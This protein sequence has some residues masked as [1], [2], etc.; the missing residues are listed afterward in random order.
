MTRLRWVAVALSLAAMHSV[1][2]ATLFE[3]TT[4]SAR[5]AQQQDLLP[6]SVDFSIT[7]PGRYT[8]TLTD[9]RSPVAL[10]S[11][12]AV[13]TR[14]LDVVAKA[15]VAYEGAA[16]D[17]PVSVAV[18]FTAQAGSYRLH[19]IGEPSSSEP[20]SFGIGVAPAGG[21]TSLID[22]VDVIANPS[23]PAAGQTV[24]RQ[25]L[26]LTAAGNH[27]LILTDLSF[28]PTTTSLQAIVLQQLPTGVVPIPV[29]A[30]AFTAP[31]PG[32]YE[33]LVLATAADGDLAGLYSI[34]LRRSADSFVVYRSVQPAGRMPAPRTLT[35]TAG[36][37]YTLDADDLR[38]PAALSSLSAAVAQDGA[39]VVRQTD[40]DP[41]SAALSAGP[42]QLF[43]MATPS[44]IDNLG[45]YRISLAQGSQSIHSELHT[46]DAVDDPASAQIY[47]FDP[48]AAANAGT[49]ALNLEDL[50][51]PAPLPALKAAVVQN[52][53]VVH[54]SP[55]AGVSNVTLQAA[56]V[57]LLVAVRPPAANGNGLFSARLLP[58]A[59]QPL[60][61]VTR[62]VGGLFH[63]ETLQI[64]T[65]GDYRVTLADLEF[66]APLQSAALALTQDSTIVAQVLG[67]TVLA[68]QRLDAGTYAVHFLGQPAFGA[69][70]ALYGV[71]I[72]DAPPVPTVTLTAT[73]S[74]V[75]SGGTTNLL[76]SSTNATSCTASGGWSG[77][78]T[79][80]GSQS[81]DALT[82]ATTF[83]L[84]CEGPGGSTSASANVTVSTSRPSGGGGG[85]GGVNVSL[86]IAMASLL[87]ASRIR[88]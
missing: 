47:A 67:D 13:V 18:E 80:N 37:T 41:V 60:I 32:N 10:E 16:E 75:T 74:S 76:W 17:Q 6:E 31:A 69:N 50:R 7:D 4:L 22:S 63:S 51:F 56:P 40:N 61:G 52:G 35:L 21:G 58:S 81:S 11:L 55:A 1:V 77:A 42:V 82:A 38:F 23:T 73:P 59:G 68:R 53:T 43:A 64:A 19:V 33:L 24:L 28:A 25:E 20:G 15:E 29:V 30:G 45:T 86:L 88:R 5:T 49:Y 12:K 85:G 72:E 84:T 9:L 48:V 14:G 44:T 78:K 2:G 57:Q 46:V 62:G 8:V 66:P 54:E 3:T 36:G 70:H 83:T 71:R 34:T 79:T 26:A 39:I 65:T 27:D 87:V